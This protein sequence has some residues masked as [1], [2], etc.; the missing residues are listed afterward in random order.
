LRASL[1]GYRPESLP[2]GQRHEEDYRDVGAIILR[3]LSRSKG[4]IMSATSGLA[5]KE[6]QKAY[7]KGLE[8]VKRNLPDAAQAEFS[9]ATSIY[10]R[11]AAAWYE[12]GQVLERRSHFADARS[13][14]SKAVASDADFLAAYE[15]LYLLDVR[16]SKWPEAVSASSRVLRRDPYDY[17]GAYY[18]NALANLQLRNLEAAERSAREAGRLQGDT[19]EPRA[20]YILGLVLARQGHTEAAVDALRVFIGGSPGGAEQK[21]AERILASLETRLRDRI[22]QQK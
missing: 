19:V 4:L 7:E 20:N 14:Y 9:R 1:R 16:E 6:A 2:L 18:V 8:A 15:R 13:A 10:A 11:Y 3:P 12:L 22:A 21:D 17:P 5:P